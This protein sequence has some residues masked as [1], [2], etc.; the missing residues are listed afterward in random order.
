MFLALVL[1]TPLP[2]FASGEDLLEQEIHA[3]QKKDFQSALA[4]GIEELKKAPGNATARYYLAQALVK[5]N[6]RDEA[7]A[8]FTECERLATEPKLSSYCRQALATLTPGKSNA[9]GAGGGTVNGAA[10][11]GGA[12]AAATGGTPEAASGSANSALNSA[13]ANRDAATN[14]DLLERRANT[15]QEG[16]HEIE[17]LRKQA[18]KKISDINDEGAAQLRDI[19]QFFERGYYIGGRFHPQHVA[20]PEYQE[21]L[22]R[23][24]A[25]SKTKIDAINADFAKRET[26]V[27]AEYK[28]RSDAYGGVMTNMNSQQ[29]PGTS[30]IQMTPQNT[31]AYVRNFVNYDGY[32]P[33]PPPVPL[34][35]QQKS[36]IPQGKPGADAPAKA[37]ANANANAK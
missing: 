16:V 27:T 6:R 9:A 23:V 3:Y 14:L 22:Q 29:K 30:L 11:T 33:P 21:A 8:Q 26:E 24:Q 13:S 36:L 35:A 32:K 7:I 31:N 1:S 17:F 19:P 37:N 5:L 10:A 12:N 2:C 20:N 4:Y 28:R 15:L 18:D 25:E 34:K